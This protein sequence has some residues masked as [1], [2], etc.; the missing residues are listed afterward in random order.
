VDGVQEARQTCNVARIDAAGMYYRDLNALLRKAASNG[1]QRIEISNVFGQ[2]YIGTDLNKVVDIEVSGTPGN[3]LGAF[4][5]GPRVIV[6]GNAQ[7][8]CGNT[9]NDGEIVIHGHAGDTVGLSARGGKI[10]VRDYVGYRAA[11]HMK[12]YGDRRPMTVVGGSGQDF[13]GEYMAGGVLVVLGLDLRD[14][15]PHRANYIGTGMHG[16]VIY[17]RGAVR[18]SQLG[19]EVG[20][21]GLEDADLAVLSGLVSEFADHFGYDAGALLSADYVK[22]YPRWLRPYGTLYAY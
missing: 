5:N 4:L 10:F 12:E 3:D 21:A 11:I 7:D 16:G 18:E 20:V 1:V 2:R 6:R 19:K 13:L 15:E 22:L 17:M 9:M 14:G 8:G